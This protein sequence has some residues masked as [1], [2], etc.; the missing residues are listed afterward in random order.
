MINERDNPV[1]WSLLL[2]DLDEARE[3]L[4]SLIHQMHQNGRIENVI[5]CFAG[6]GNPFR[7]GALRPGEKVVDLGCGAG[8]DSF[9]AAKMVGPQGAVI[10]VDMT[11]EMLDKAQAAREESGLSQAEFRRGY[12]EEIPVEDGWADVIISNGAVNLAP[13]KARVYGE[14]FRL[15]K[16]GGRF[17]LADM[18]WCR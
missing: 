17:Q 12:F 16:P 8:I 13:D 10:G 9:I 18:G 5:E 6:T 11:Q 3:H 15:L 7:Q 2:Q 14:M 4:E 1:A